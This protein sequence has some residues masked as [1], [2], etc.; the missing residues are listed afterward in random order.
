LH[1]VTEHFLE[2][3]VPA[4]KHQADGNRRLHKFVVVL[5]VVLVACFGAV[6]VQLL[7][8]AWLSAIQTGSVALITGVVVAALRRGV[9]ITTC[10]AVYLALG[11]GVSGMMALQGGTNG[12]VSA[13][14]MSAAPL[15]GLTVGG[16]RFGYVTL[17]ITLVAMGLTLWCLEHGVAPSMMLEDDATF[18]VRSASLIGAVIT[19]FFLVHN[20]DLEAEKS[21]VRL[22]EKNQALDDARREA[23]RAN[24]T[25]SEFLATISHEIRTPLNGITGVISL[26]EN[27][28][29]LNQIQEY[30]R[31]IRHS[32]D[33][34]LALIN[35]VL[36]LAKI[37]SERLE[38]DFTPMSPRQQA[39]AVVELLAARA[40]ENQTRLELTV[41]THIPEWVLT[42]PVRWRQVALNLASNAVKFTRGGTVKIRIGGDASTLVLEVSDSGIGMD[43]NAKRR[44]FT[45]FVQADASTTRRFGGTGLGL[46]ISKRLVSA[47]NGHLWFE[48]TLGVGSTF[49][50][51]VP[52]EPTVAPRTEPSEPAPLDQPSRRVLLVEDNAVNQMVALRLLQRAGHSVMVAANG[53]R[54]LEICDD[55]RFDAILM[56]CHMPE[57]DGFDATDALRKRGVTTPIY[58]LT[59]A[60]TPED[61]ARCLKVGMD[62]LIP[63]PLNVGRLASLLQRLP[64]HE[65]QSR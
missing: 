42:D 48:S 44:I 40:A 39:A 4:L 60:V 36:D 24:R 10:A 22:K 57:L 31:V 34:L 11:V 2:R 45:P 53:K 6:A 17:A 33:T 50:V 64:R 15:I 18:G 19:L 20:Y 37:E 23:D 13:F 58:A 9:S 1:Q 32:A 12:M 8:G 62:A 26:M 14:W 35:D 51:S 54:A 38:L 16:R 63:K 7:S 56:D 55:N 47:M 21:I 28:N 52:V 29:D 49:R 41:E 30:N 25:K 27:E 43:D 65:V 59:A 46:A 3:L 61:E 5:M